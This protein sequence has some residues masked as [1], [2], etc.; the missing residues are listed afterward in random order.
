M[1][2]I[3]ES[4]GEAFSGDYGGHG[5]VA[6]AEGRCQLRIT[7]PLDLSAGHR[8]LV[9]A[10]VE[11]GLQQLGERR[12]GLGQV[13]PLVSSRPRREWRACISGV[14]LAIRAA[15]TASSACWRSAAPAFRCAASF[16][17]SWALMRVT[18]CGLDSGG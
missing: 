11:A 15:F 3:E 7:D 5:V 10:G 16:A 2:F 4:A 18:Y 12:L 17:A 8:D 14:A 6:L 1:V 9:V 13:G